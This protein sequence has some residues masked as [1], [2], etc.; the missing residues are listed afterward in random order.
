MQIDGYIKGFG[1]TYD[2]YNPLPR[3]KWGTVSR[4]KVP[5]YSAVYG[6]AD[7]YRYQMEFYGV[8]KMG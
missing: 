3:D 8:G 7:Q 6:D 1:I 2:R 4:G 5:E